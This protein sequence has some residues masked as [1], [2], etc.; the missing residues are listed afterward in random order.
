MQAKPM[1]QKRY[2]GRDL[3]C[4]ELRDEQLAQLQAALNPSL[5]YLNKLHSRCCKKLAVND[6]LAK[7][8]KAALDAVNCLWMCAENLRRQ[9][10]PQRPQMP[11]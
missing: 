8:A 9:D 5:D 6:E 10:P 7:R 1:P 4:T 3:E 11:R 2:P